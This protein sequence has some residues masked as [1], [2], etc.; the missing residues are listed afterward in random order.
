MGSM[1]SW[2]KPSSVAVLDTNLRLGPTIILCSKALNYFVFPIHPLDGTHTQSM[3]H[4]SQGLKIL[5][6][7][8]SS[9]SSTLTEVDLYSGINKGS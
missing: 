3:S 6:S 5:I 1:G 8:I 7:A 9:P 2:K 4:L